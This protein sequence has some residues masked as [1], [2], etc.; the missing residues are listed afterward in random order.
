MAAN[1]IK[2]IFGAGQNT[3]LDSCCGSVKITPIDETAPE[4][5]VQK[6]ETEAKALT[7][8]DR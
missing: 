7:T 6:Q 4:A 8:E 2:K 5:E 1:F 3:D